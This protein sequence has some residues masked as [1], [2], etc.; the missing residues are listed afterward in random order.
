MFLCFGRICIGQG[1][2][3]PDA[4]RARLLLPS[5]DRK[6]PQT[7]L[8]VF[9]DAAFDGGMRITSQTIVCAS[10]PKSGGSTRDNWHR[11]SPHLHGI[12]GR[13]PWCCVPSTGGS[14]DA[15]KPTG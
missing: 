1:W 9:L 12:E 13:E 10:L 4:A 15:Q 6:S 14:P 7:E 8:L 3:L 11:R 5:S 2:E